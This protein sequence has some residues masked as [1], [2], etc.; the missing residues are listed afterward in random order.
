MVKS[1]QEVFQEAGHG[2][3]VLPKG[4]ELSECPPGGS[5]KARRPSQRSGRGWEALPVGLGWVKGL[6]GALRVVGR[7]T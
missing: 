1:C 4:Q 3:E 6:L 5:E 7:S 2:R